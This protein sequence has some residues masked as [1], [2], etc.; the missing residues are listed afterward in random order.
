MTKA[1]IRG[2]FQAGKMSEVQAEHWLALFGMTKI[3]ADCYIGNPPY[4][5]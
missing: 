2:L 5:N 4:S 1:Q 3:E